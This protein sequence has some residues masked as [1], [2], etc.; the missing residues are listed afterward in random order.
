MASKAASLLSVCAFVS[1]A[2]LVIAGVS[3]RNNGVVASAIVPIVVAWI[4]VRRLAPLS[5]GHDI[6]LYRR[7]IEMGAVDALEAERERL[8]RRRPFNLLVG[9]LLLVAI[10][11][12]VIQITSM[13]QAFDAR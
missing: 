8:R 5:S 13:H 10:A 11:Y 7:M 2:A 3:L 12:I 9:I 6:G 1:S 4:A